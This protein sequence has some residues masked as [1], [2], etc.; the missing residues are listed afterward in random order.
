MIINDHNNTN[1]KTQAKRSSLSCLFNFFF[2][3]LEKTFTLLKH[4]HPLTDKYKKISNRK[5]KKFILNSRINQT[6]KN[7]I[8]TENRRRINKI[9]IY[10]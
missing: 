10:I 5:E 7:E 8:S 3:L 6:N 1:E 4:L 9:Y 2:A